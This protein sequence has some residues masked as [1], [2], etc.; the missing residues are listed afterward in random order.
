MEFV[1]QADLLWVKLTFDSVC[2]NWT[3]IL[4]WVLLG[5]G[6]NGIPK[7]KKEWRIM[8]VSWDLQANLWAGTQFLWRKR[9]KRRSV[10]FLTWGGIR[11]LWYDM[12][13]QFDAERSFVS[14]YPRIL[15]KNLWTFKDIL[16]SY[17]RSSHMYLT[18]SAMLTKC[19]FTLICEK[20]ETADG[21]RL[22]PYIKLNQMTI[23]KKKVFLVT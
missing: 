21:N 5:Q 8:F 9:Q 22:L 11:D 13:F 6:I 19:Q 7:W 14:S 16:L 1:L 4:S 20:T 23:S 17:E 10:I 18:I 3:S 12:V 2:K 15:K